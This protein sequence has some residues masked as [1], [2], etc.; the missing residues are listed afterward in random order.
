MGSKL[1]TSICASSIVTKVR[2][3]ELLIGEALL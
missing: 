1:K 3:S 2:N